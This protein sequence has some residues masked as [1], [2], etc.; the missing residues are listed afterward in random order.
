MRAISLWQ[1]W[2]QL[3]ASGDK[4]FETRGW[5]PPIALIGQTIAIHAAKKIDKE[6][7]SLADDIIYGQHR[8]GG[9]ELAKRV[10]ATFSRASDDVLQG[11]GMA[12]LPAGAVVC[13]AKLEAA[14][15]LGEP[16]EGAARVVRRMIS[17]PMP[18]CFTV[19]YDDFG[20]YAA[21]RWAWL[22]TDVRPINPPI[23]VT[24]RQGF[25]ELP[26]GWLAGE[27]A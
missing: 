22:L 14:F 25:F 16:A 2:A 12:V 6:A 17:R 24:G 26:Q 15:E 8:A 27:A 1:P 4:P 3:I 7:C 11:F 23:A 9:F 10:E 20:N 18:D 21:G 5:A 19:R 13:T